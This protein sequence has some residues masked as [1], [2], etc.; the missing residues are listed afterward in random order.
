M[1][2]AG[3]APLQVYTRKYFISG[4]CIERIRERMSARKATHLDDDSL[5]NRIDEALVDAIAAGLVTHILDNGTPAK[6]VNVTDAFQEGLHILVKPDEK[7]LNYAE[8]AVTVFTTNQYESSMKIKKWPLLGAKEQTK[9][10]TRSRTASGNGFTSP[11][12]LSAS[13]E[14][15][16]GTI[17][18]QIT[19]RP[20]I[21][22]PVITDEIGL[23]FYKTAD[24]KE[25]FERYPFGDCPQAA[26]DIMGKSNYLPSSLEVY[27]KVAVKTRVMIG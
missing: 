17:D 4:H 9:M 24:G 8:A 5:G 13:M 11:G 27:V 7:K 14:E 26:G 23:L 16:V 1:A 21:K 2:M 10:P 3:R 15:H 6:I 22:A 19:P 25:H 12:G 20:A 18:L